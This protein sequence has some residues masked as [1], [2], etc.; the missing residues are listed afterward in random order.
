MVRIYKDIEIADFEAW[1]GAVKVLEKIEE[2]GKM[3]EL[4]EIVE[5]LFPDGCSETELNDYL[6]FDALDNIDTEISSE[7]MEELRSYLEE[8]DY[9][10]YEEDDTFEIWNEEGD[11]LIATVTDMKDSS[12]EVL[13]YHENNQNVK[14]ETLLQNPNIE[15][16]KAE[17][18][19]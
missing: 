16:L 19:N 15:E 13:R 10:W 6:W 18:F 2:A 14:N 11:T 5:E 17:I 9:D 12:I 1:S 4:N 3:D 8:S 7:A